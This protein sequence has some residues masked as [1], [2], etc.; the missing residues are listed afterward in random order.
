LIGSLPQK[1]LA[2]RAVVLFE[3]QEP[4]SFVREPDGAGSW[5]RYQWEF[6]AYGSTAG[7]GTAR[8][9]LASSQLL[10][11]SESDPLTIDVLQGGVVLKQIEFRPGPEPIELLLQNRATGHGPHPINYD[12]HFLVYYELAGQ[13]EP[14]VDRRIPHLY[15]SAV[16]YD[17]A[18]SSVFHLNCAA[19]LAAAASPLKG[20]VELE[21]IFGD[22]AKEDL[23]NIELVSSVSTAAET[24]LHGPPLCPQAALERP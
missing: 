16:P 1:F 7:S 11:L 10:T 23:L 17:E 13:K 14:A 3:K 12:P 19:I 6:R 5:R 8:R 21:S 18:C 9:L 15:G 2:S 24:C 22:M 20:A 4:C